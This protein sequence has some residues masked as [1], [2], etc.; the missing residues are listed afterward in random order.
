[1]LYASMKIKN[2]Q[3]NDLLL[4]FDDAVNEKNANVLILIFH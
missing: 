2:F 4:E 1:M 3:I